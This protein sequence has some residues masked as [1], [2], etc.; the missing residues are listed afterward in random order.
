MP[1][2]SQPHDDGDGDGGPVFTL[3]TGL[4]SPTLLPAIAALVEPELMRPMPAGLT[5]AQQEQ[6]L[7]DRWNALIAD[8]AWATALATLCQLALRDEVEVAQ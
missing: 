7:Q 2:D 3:I 8:D 5:I 6:V 1:Y 4:R